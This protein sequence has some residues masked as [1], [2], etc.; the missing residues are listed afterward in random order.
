MNIAVLGTAIEA[1][2]LG[3]KVVVPPDCIAGD[4][5]E[6]AEHVV[7]YTMRN[8]AFVVPSTTIT[9]AWR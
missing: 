7:R 4:P 1:M 9:A 6:Y 8:I 2:N 5:Y 3:Y